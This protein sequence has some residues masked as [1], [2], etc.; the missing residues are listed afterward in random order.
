ML[1][2]IKGHDFIKLRP[3]WA[4]GTVEALFRGVASPRTMDGGWTSCDRIT[5]TI[6]HMHCGYSTGRLSP[7]NPKP[8][9]ANPNWLR[10]IL[11]K[12]GVIPN[13][14]PVGSPM[15]SKKICRA[16]VHLHRSGLGSLAP[17]VRSIWGCPIN[18]SHPSHT[19]LRFFL[20]EILRL[21]FRA[22]PELNAVGAGI[23]A[24][25]VW[26]VLQASPFCFTSNGEP[27]QTGEQ[28]VTHAG[29]QKM[30]SGNRFGGLHD[31]VLGWN[32]RTIFR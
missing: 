6:T 31:T 21:R 27:C 10:E 2:A 19:S 12:Q 32:R 26:I 17:D 5:A 11:A 29:F 30:P 9:E 25:A 22:M 7:G 20:T 18:R 15:N 24:D 4:V 14:N 8:K 16:I 13:W 23:G 1:P 28:G 3:G